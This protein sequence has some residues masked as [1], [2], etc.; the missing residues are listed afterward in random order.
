MVIFL[1]VDN[2]NKKHDR[3]N[4]F[5]V[6]DSINQEVPETKSSLISVS[7]Y[8]VCV[9]DLIWNYLM[10]FTAFKLDLFLVK[11]I[12]HNIR[13]V[14]LIWVELLFISLFLVV[15]LASLCWY[16][17]TKIVR[18]I[19][20]I[21]IFLLS[22]KIVKS[23]TIHI[24]PGITFSKSFCIIVIFLLRFKLVRSHIFFHL[25]FL[26]NLSSFILF[27]LILFFFLE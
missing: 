9:L 22:V 3:Q 6:N 19:V 23:I 17:H 2:K 20:L 16:A 10:N 15:N 18:V 1:R 12:F 8:L 25:T 5:K 24:D 26:S 14:P 7:I 21:V 4:I 13:I 11:L 27:R